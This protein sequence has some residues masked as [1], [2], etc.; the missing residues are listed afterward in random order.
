MPIVRIEML[1][2]RSQETKQRLATEMTTLVAREL[3][4]DAA[5]IYVMFSE[6]AHNDWAVAGQFFPQPPSA[7]AAKE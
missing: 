6:V 4:V 5:H 1:P 3:G 2:G 7:Q